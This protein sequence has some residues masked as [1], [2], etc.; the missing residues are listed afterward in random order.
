MLVPKGYRVLARIPRLN[1]TVIAE[2]AE[3]FGGLPKLVQAS[4]VGLTQVDGVGEVRARK[5]REGLAR[6]L[7]ASSLG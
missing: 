2:V 7:E 4:V 3:H 6:I 1:D 5:I